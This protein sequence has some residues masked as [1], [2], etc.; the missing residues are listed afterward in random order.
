MHNNF[1]EA[2]FPSSTSTHCSSPNKG[3]ENPGF[4]KAEDDIMKQKPKKVSGNL[5]KGNVGFNILCA[6]VF[7]GINL[8]L[9]YVISTF[10]MGLNSAEVTTICFIY[11]CFVQLFH[12]FNLKNPNQSLF[13]GNPFDNKTL[14]WCFLLSAGLTVI[15]LLVPIAPIQMA[16]G[17]TLISWW[18][19]LIALGLALLV[20]PYFELIKFFVRLYKRKKK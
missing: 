20:I 2:V 1:T 18:H 6:S 4:E 5:F 14:N 10:V 15:V 12:A 9:L 17:V 16:F 7:V 19:W 3:L 13:K 8:I 11:L